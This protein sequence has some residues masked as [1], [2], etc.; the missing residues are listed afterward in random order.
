MSRKQIDFSSLDASS[1]ARYQQKISLIGNIDPYTVPKK[2]WSQDIDD[3]PAISFLDITTYLV[4][5]LS[6]YTM[7]EFRAY[8]SLRPTISLFL[9]GSKKFVSRK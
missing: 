7:E 4:L 3:Y 5:H 1:K 9:V 6:A 8:K 2:E